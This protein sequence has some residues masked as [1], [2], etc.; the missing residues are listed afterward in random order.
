[1]NI[2]IIK[3][4]EH[5]FSKKL[6]SI[7]VLKLKENKFYIGKSINV[8]KRIKQHFKGRGSTWTRLYQPTEIYEIRRNCDV[9]DEEKITL[10]YMQLYGIN[11]VRGGSYSRICL[12]KY[13]INQVVRIIRSSEDRCYVC[14]S[15]DHFAKACSKLFCKKC[16][17]NGHSYKDCRFFD[18]DNIEHILT[19][20]EIE[21]F[22]VDSDTDK[23]YNE[24]P[25]KKPSKIKLLFQ[26]IFKNN[27]KF[28]LN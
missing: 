26:K 5:I 9:F 6:Y 11:N 7:Y 18:F 13:E 19:D 22:I 2:N 3:S 15:K 1:M 16:K 10:Q 8:N 24:I 23:I 21:N 20:E 17:H 12:D 14:G 28:I 4:K 25:I 27:L